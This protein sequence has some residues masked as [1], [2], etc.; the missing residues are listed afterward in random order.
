MAVAAEPEDFCINFTE[1]KFIDGALYFKAEDDENLES[2]HFGRLDANIAILRN[3]RDQVL[4]TSQGNQ[5]LFEDMPDLDCKEN[6][7]QIRLIIYK[8]KDSLRRGIGVSIS[9][10][11]MKTST[12]SCKD[13]KLIFQE[14][15]PP[16]D[17]DSE[18]SD[19]I[20][21][22]KSATGYNDKMEF[23][24][25]LY[26]GYFLAC[27]KENDLY[28]LILKEKKKDGNIMPDGT[29]IFTI[30]ISRENM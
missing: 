14:R 19:I 8:Y 26:R 29:I 10:R 3:M 7:S 24:S 15:D 6:E 23:E 12:L 5:P 27:K 13:K 11:H 17:I 18:E 21:F 2:D 22:M 20:F 1:M 4:I 9:V 28:K 16:Q 30:E 25:S